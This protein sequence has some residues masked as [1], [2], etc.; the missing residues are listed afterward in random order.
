MAEADRVYA[1]SLAEIREAADLTQSALA[2][3]MDVAQ[4]VI[5][6]LERQHDMLLITLIG[7]LQA[8][9]HPGRDGR[10]ATTSSWTGPRGPVT[11]HPP[12]LSLPHNPPTPAAAGRRKG[13]PKAQP[14]GPRSALPPTKA[15]GMLCRFGEG[16]S[17]SAMSGA[18]PG[19]LAS[20][21]EVGATIARGRQPQSGEVVSKAQ[22]SAS[23]PQD[24]RKPSRT[25]IT[26]R[27]DPT[28]H[29]CSSGR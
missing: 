15:A 2:T 4:T 23:C 24:V 7:Y 21:T 9:D 6:R 19:R 18:P 29:L 10:R 12:L 28:P 16:M 3:Q 25:I 20:S 17:G 22:Q 26:D 1:Q 13:G 5:S 14:E 11:A 27:P 8:A